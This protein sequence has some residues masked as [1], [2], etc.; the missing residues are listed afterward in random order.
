MKRKSGLQKKISSIFDGVS[1]PDMGETGPPKPS[2]LDQDL[3]ATGSDDAPFTQHQGP[4]RPD[5]TRPIDPITENHL[6]HIDSADQ[7]NQKFAS[8]LESALTPS[9]PEDKQDYL[10]LDHETIPGQKKSPPESPTQR[11]SMPSGPGPT[12]PEQPSI[13]LQSPRDTVTQ[14]LSEAAPAYSI[15]QKAMFFFMT[16][17]FVGF[18]LAVVRAVNPSLLTGPTP[19][20]TEPQTVK[21]AVAVAR[22]I[23]WNIPESYPLDLPDPMERF[24]AKPQLDPQLHLPFDPQTDPQTDP[25]P[26]PSPKD[27]IVIK[28]I[29]YSDDRPSVIIGEEILSE[30]DL[31]EGAIIK[32]INRNHVVFEWK[33]QTWSGQLE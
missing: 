22:S 10:L 6:A 29:L 13:Q 8:R 4:S 16:I 21:L 27:L 31:V 12:L 25:Q 30:G 33:D 5:L 20:K 18:G 15:R 26:E 11:P 32:K 9:R 28:G 19:V 17:L 2:T 3:I 14:A 24:I 1:I 7:Q 23:Q